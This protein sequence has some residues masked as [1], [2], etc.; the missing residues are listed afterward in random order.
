MQG[1][2]LPIY[3]WYDEYPTHADR[4]YVGRVAKVERADSG[5]GLASLN[6][7]NINEK[8]RG[9]YNCKV[10][11]LNRGPDLAVVSTST[12]RHWWTLQR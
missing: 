4:D 3:I 11:F 7:T 1:K 2:E 8:D 6:I 9:W 12:L 5:Y 10:L